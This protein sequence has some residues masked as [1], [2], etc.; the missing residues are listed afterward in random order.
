MSCQDHGT[1]C[2]AKSILMRVIIN[3]ALA[4][5]LAT[6]ALSQTTRNT[7]VAATETAAAM[8]KELGTPVPHVIITDYPI[9]VLG[10]RYVHPGEKVGGTLYERP[11]ILLRAELLEYAKAELDVFLFHEMQHLRMDQ[12]GRPQELLDRLQGL[13]KKISDGFDLSDIPAALRGKILS[14]LGERA[15]SIIEHAY[16]CEEVISRYGGVKDAIAAISQ[17]QHYLDALRKDL[18]AFW[19]EGGELV[20]DGRSYEYSPVNQVSTWTIIVGSWKPDCSTYKTTWHMSTQGMDANID[21]INCKRMLPGTHTEQQRLPNMQGGYTIVETVST[22]SPWAIE[23]N[24]DVITVSYS[25]HAV[26][27]CDGHSIVS[28]SK[29]QSRY[30]I[31]GTRAHWVESYYTA[32][33]ITT[34]TTAAGSKKAEL[35]VVSENRIRL[36]GESPEVGSVMELTRMK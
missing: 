20:I 2:L 7:L 34:K 25:T 11:T 18:D 6:S 1:K 8:S 33:G 9:G 21:A 10:G 3:I 26:G 15:A 31:A 14:A 28:D 32:D 13:N 27:T 4:I 12:L 29:N 5:V 24:G 22:T 19:S 35:I 23:V 36:V 17:Q 16:I 30:R